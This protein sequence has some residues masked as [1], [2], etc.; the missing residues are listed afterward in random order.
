MSTDT[1]VIEYVHTLAQELPNVS[2][3]DSAIRYAV[4]SVTMSLVLG[5]AVGIQ[6]DQTA[7]LFALSEIRKL[8]F[9]VDEP[10]EWFR[11]K[12]VWSGDDHKLFKIAKKDLE[13][14]ECREAT[15]QIII[16]Y[17]TRAVIEESTGNPDAIGLAY[18]NLISL[19]NSAKKKLIHIFKQYMDYQ[20]ESSSERLN[21][22]FKDT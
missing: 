17:L 15:R 4:G 12:L 21:R 9:E 11:Q 5:D 20:K 3:L 10:P 8:P 14:S 22:I 16:C 2:R 19:K 7:L 6:T 18:A 13:D 1:K